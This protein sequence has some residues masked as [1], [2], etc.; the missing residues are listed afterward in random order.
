MSSINVNQFLNDYTARVSDRYGKDVEVS[1]GEVQQTEV[2]GVKTNTV[3]FSVTV[4][5]VTTTQTVVLPELDPPTGEGTE[6]LLDPEKLEELQDKINSLLDELRDAEKTGDASK[7]KSLMYDIY[8][9]MSLL[10]ACAMTLRKGA[11]EQRNQELE[12]QAGLHRSKADSIRDAASENW[13]MAIASACVSGF[14]TVGGLVA[15]GVASVKTG[16]ADVAVDLKN[17]MADMTAANLENSPADANVAT[18][19]AMEKLLP[20]QQDLVRAAFKDT[21]VE[22]ANVK[23]QGDLDKQVKSLETKIDLNQQ[24]MAGFDAE[25]ALE[26]NGQQKVAEAQ[27]KIDEQKTLRDEAKKDI[28][29]QEGTVAELT[30]A[31][32]KEASGLRK[33]TS[34]LA[35]LQKKLYKA[36]SANPPDSGSV[37][38]IKAEIDKVQ[39]RIDARNAKIAQNMQDIDVC[40]LQIGKQQKVVDS[41]NAEIARQ[42]AFIDGTKMDQNGF[43]EL[44]ENTGSLEKM[45]DQMKQRMEDFGSKEAIDKVDAA[46]KDKEKEI[47]DLGSTL[48]EKA[49]DV[50]T[51]NTKLNEQNEQLRNDIKE[52]QDELDVS[53]PNSLSD[54]DPDDIKK[55]IQNCQNQI[56]KNEDQIAENNKA[57]NDGKTLLDNAQK[58][59]IGLKAQRSAMGAPG[60][61]ID[62]KFRADLRQKVMDDYVAF[63][64]TVKKQVAAGMPKEQGEKLLQAARLYKTQRLA[65][66]S[67]PK[68]VEMDI[69]A[70]EN[71]LKAVETTYSQN[72]DVRFWNN[73][74]SGAQTINQLMA[75]LSNL[76]QTKG[77]TAVKEAEA[78]EMEMDAEIKET[79]IQMNDSEQTWQDMQKLIDM[80]RQLIKEFIS[81]MSELEGTVNRNFA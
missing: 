1:F 55:E 27:G 22:A 9:M 23:M 52:L 21:D 54:A 76:I 78:D 48:S 4:N 33:D 41:C 64:D 3:Q 46:I 18:Q 67:T 59:L 25:H 32:K 8:E 2:N 42:N 62:D 71:A 68:Q 15:Q 39:N 49:K 29:T 6:Y 50:E 45:R 14:L 73:I 31:N 30:K 38:K 36:E 51:D 66:I 13:S 17:S 19:T 57:V 58:D 72:A 56:K 40:Q 74:A 60:S 65:E 80:V 26:G 7:L 53:D 79:E 11:H 5:G 47:Q 34:K 43:E 81:S 37:N 10:L 77:Q 35:D 70:A 69:K 24:K 12:M 61:K 20:D 63:S 16:N 28:D 44:K 75:P